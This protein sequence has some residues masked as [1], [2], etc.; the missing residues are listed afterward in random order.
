MKLFSPLVAATVICFWSYADAGS[1]RKE[2]AS[3]P[4]AYTSTPDVS[5][6][7]PRVKSG[8][9]GRHG[10]GAHQPRKTSKTVGGCGYQF[11]APGTSL[12]FTSQRY[13]GFY[14]NKV[15]CVWDFQTT[16]GS[17][18]RL[19]CSPFKLQGSR[20][21]RKDFLQVTTLGFRRRFCG[22]K[23][24][25]VVSRNTRRI[26]TR[27]R[28][29]GRGSSRGFS[30]SISASGTPAPPIECDCG[31]V[32]RVTRIVGGVE[33]EVNEYPWMVTLR[34][35]GS[36]SHFCGASVLA[37]GWVLTA[38]HC[39]EG[40]GASDLVV[41]VGDH[42]VTADDET[43]AQVFN[44][45]QIVNH[46]MY[47][48]NTLE[49]D[50]ALL[51]LASQIQF[52]EDNAV[53]RVCLPEAGR[54][55]D[56]VTATVSGWG[57]V[58]EDGAASPVL[59]EVSVPTMSNAVCN[60]FMGGAVTA[61]MLCAGVPEGG[62]DSCQGDSGGP[63]VTEEDGKAKQIG[64]VSWGY[65]CAQPNSPGVYARVTAYLTWI[66]SYVTEC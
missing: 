31:S 57:A 51:R 2:G 16:Q 39:T 32:N 56:S 24:A 7:E 49:N 62:L 28:T 15:N 12:V 1:H 25:F 41:V 27:F 18:L 8:Q 42:D 65:G 33:T 37:S 21:C 60:G 53:G 9:T 4:P 43:N 35:S 10:N 6:F 19:Q 55:Y 46:P 38:A 30:C 23:R 17:T 45:A 66:S 40:M 52:P 54:A 22:K 3:M 26:V 20:R 47:D 29:N 44:V 61:N 36:M 50:I 11:I 34:Y 58:L 59:L 63:L 13:P 64:V 14:P 5:D 48:D